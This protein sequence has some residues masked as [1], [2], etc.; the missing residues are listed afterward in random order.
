IGLVEW[1]YDSHAC[2]RFDPDHPGIREGY[3]YVDHEVFQIPYGVVVPKVIDGLLVPVACS[4]SHIAYNALRMEPV[5]MALGEACGQAAH[6][7]VTTRGPVRSVPVDHLQQALLA[8]GGVITYLDDLA[9]DN[10]AFAACQWLG[11]RGFNKGYQA[12]ADRPVSRG[13]SAERLGRV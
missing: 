8:N 4:A 6:L 9:R 11:A 7:A 12:E 13:E 3:T 1:Q 10:D 2:H 5:F